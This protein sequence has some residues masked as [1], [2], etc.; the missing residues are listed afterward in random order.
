MELKEFI[1]ETLVQMMEGVKNAQQRSKEFGGFVNPEDQQKTSTHVGSS[2]WVKIQPVDFEISLTE[3]SS[4]DSQ[5]GISVNFGGIGGKGGKEKNEQSTSLNKI[6]FTIPVILPYV[7]A[8]N[9]YEK[10]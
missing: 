2:H 7:D 5:K 6:K 4:S 8:A 10:E 1:T 3:T 9:T